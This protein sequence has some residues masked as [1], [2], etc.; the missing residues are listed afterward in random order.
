[1]QLSLSYLLACLQLSVWQPVLSQDSGGQNN[2][3]QSLR[4]LSKY[5][6]CVRDSDC[7]VVKGQTEKHKCF[8]YM[9]Y[10]KDT[11]T[12]FRWCSKDKDCAKLTAREEGDGGDGKCFKHPDKNNV[13]FGICLKKM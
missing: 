8:Q 13:E 9:C 3:T 10:P 4:Q 7:D 11:S 12:G 5:P 6:A 1:M 2:R